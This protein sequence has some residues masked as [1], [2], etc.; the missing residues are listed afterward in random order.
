MGIVEGLKESVVGILETLVLL[1]EIS[2]SEQEAL[3]FVKAISQLL[4][5]DT[6]ATIVGNAWQ[7]KKG[8]YL[9]EEGEMRTD[10]D[11]IFNFGVDIGAVVGM[12]LEAYLTAGMSTAGTGAN[13]TRGT[14]K[15]LTEQAVRQAKQL[16]TNLNKRAFD[17]A[18]K[19]LN[20]KALAKLADD[21]GDAVDSP[22]ARALNE[23]PE[24]VK[25][26]DDAEIDDRLRKNVLNVEIADKMKKPF[27]DTDAFANN[28]KIKQVIEG[29]DQLGDKGKYISETIKKGDF[30]DVP[31]YK[32][33]IGTIKKSG[34]PPPDYTAHPSWAVA[35]T[36]KKAEKATGVPNARKV[37][38]DVKN[39]VH[40]IDYA[41]LATSG[42]KKYSK[43]FQF[44]S[45]ASTSKV[46]KAIDANKIASQLKNADASKRIFEVE[47][48]SDTLSDLSQ[49]S[50]SIADRVANA[51]S[52]VPDLVINITDSAGNIIKTY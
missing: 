2:T 8:Q 51:K 9:D 11:A 15:E 16:L 28:K 5:I 31:G 39:G 47:M 34:N 6:M 33:L 19:L 43:A 45:V 22:L 26:L 17:A 4:D 13:L 41:E 42:A 20:G 29:A 1:L 49:F 3:Q 24:L 37:F 25:V 10:S 14:L 32:K 40:D 18:E 23:K 48:R 38:E 35:Q 12:L 52:L 30:N 27:F 50:Q 7:A 44:K 21:I 46:A 36:L